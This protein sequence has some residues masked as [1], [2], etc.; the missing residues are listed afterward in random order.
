MGDLGCQFCIAICNMKPTGKRAAI[1]M[2]VRNKLP[3]WAL[4]GNLD[5][6]I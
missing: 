4:G 2:E 5:E 3:K 1:A 6:L